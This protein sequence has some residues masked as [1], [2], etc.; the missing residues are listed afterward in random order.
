[1]KDLE[2]QLQEQE[3][4]ANIAIT[5]WQDVCSASEERCFELEKELESMSAKGQ[6]LSETVDIEENHDVDIV[7]KGS[8]PEEKDP[9]MDDKV[10]SLEGELISKTVPFANDLQSA[11]D[12]SSP[13]VT[14]AVESEA[15][16]A[17][18]R[19]TE[20]ELR[21]AKESLARS[22]TIV[23][24]L[25][26]NFSC[27]RN[28][29]IWSVGTHFIL[30]CF[31][32]RIERIVELESTTKDLENQ[33]QEQDEESMKVITQWQEASSLAEGK[34]TKLER[35]LEV[36]TAEKETLS[37]AV[38]AIEQDNEELEGTKRLFEEK[39]ASMENLSKSSYGDSPGSQDSEDLAKQCRENEEALREAQETLARDVDVVNQWEG[40]FHAVSFALLVEVVVSH[41]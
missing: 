32:P 1:M 18:S 40:M 20:D 31:H 28:L 30:D 41:F 15:L 4:E 17:Y 36:V 5:R 22:E 9:S 10:D 27:R 33:I 29:L 24:Q 8:A 2:A 3:Q 6:P 26:G 21:Q 12:A 35:E 23:H 34:C 38:D 37:K 7:G 39:I 13:E 11:S 16:M 25:E 14:T 19:Q